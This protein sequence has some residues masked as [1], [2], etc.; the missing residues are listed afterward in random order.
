VLAT[1]RVLAN[2]ELVRFLDAN[3][4]CAGSRCTL[5]A[6]CGGRGHSAGIR[7]V[8][9]KRV[10]GE[11]A[12]VGLAGAWGLFRGVGQSAPSGG[13]SSVIPWRSNMA[14]ASSRLKVAVLVAGPSSSK[15][16]CPPPG[17]NTMMS[18]A[19]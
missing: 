14:E 15:N 18:S 5:A 19:G 4:L 10:W 3:Q 13:P 17:A 1:V 16:L 9:T 11:L 6:L 8:A 2:A 12:C 7:A